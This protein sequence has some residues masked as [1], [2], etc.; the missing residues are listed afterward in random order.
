[1]KTIP[2]I[3]LCFLFASCGVTKKVSQERQISKAV[4]SYYAVDEQPDLL[5]KGNLEKVD[6][7]Y[8]NRDMNTHTM[9]INIG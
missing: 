4:V 9:R 2:I 1:M 6:T 5:L 3:I 7:F 8:Y